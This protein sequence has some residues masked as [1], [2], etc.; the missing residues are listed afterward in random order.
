MPYVLVQN[1][2]V[3]NGPR[4]WNYRSFESSL[5]EDCGLTYQLP[6]SY[7]DTTP[8]AIADNV[9]IYWAELQPHDYNEKI[10]Y[11]HGP[12]WDFSTAVAI[13]TYETVQYAV[14]VVQRSLKGRIAENRWKKEIA[15]TTVDV[16]E[17]SLSVSTKRED[18]NQWAIWYSQGVDNLQYKN[19]TEWITLTNS[20]IKTIADAVHDYVQT[21]YLWEASQDA[22]IDA[23]TSLEELDAV[24]L[25][26]I[27]PQMLTINAPESIGIGRPMRSTRAV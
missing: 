7:S 20:D 1:H 2:Q 5:S 21:Q 24:D 3:I 8:I 15:G 18:R 25:G 16:Q 17:V 13:G 9:T 27:L 4:E 22:V 23:C 26:N 10:E 11:L 12:F 6:L 19:N 14:D